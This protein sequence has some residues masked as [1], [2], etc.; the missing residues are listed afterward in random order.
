MHLMAIDENAIR[1]DIANLLL[2]GWPEQVVMGFMLA[3]AE[4][5]Q[6]AEAR[7]ILDRIGEQAHGGDPI[8]KARVEHFNDLFIDELKKRQA[9]V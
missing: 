4:A 5:A 3:K 2:K 9:D 1:A 8:K 6:W 7:A